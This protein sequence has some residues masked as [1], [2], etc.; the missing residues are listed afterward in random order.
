MNHLHGICGD[1]RES[2]EAV[3]LAARLNVS[4]S[5][6]RS[7]S[8][9]ISLFVALSVVLC[10][11]AAAFERTH[12]CY[13]KADGR[14]PVCAKG[15]ASIP[16]RWMD[17]CTTWRH[18]E[19]FPAEFLP[20]VSSSFD[21][22][23]VVNGAYFEV[24][25]AGST[26]QFGA[27]YDCKVSLDDNE[28]VVSYVTDW[29]S[30]LAGSDVVALTSV[31]YALDDGEIL[32]ADIRMNGEHFNWEEIKDVSY[33]LQRV[34][35][36]NI[37]THE[38][39]HFLGLDHTQERNYLGDGM[40]MDAT[41]WALTFS[42]EIKRRVLDRDDMAGLREIYPSDNAPDT[43]C[44]PPERIGHKELP[45]GFEPGRHICPTS[46]RGCDAAG[47]GSSVP[48]E[49]LGIAV[50]FLAILRLRARSYR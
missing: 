7:I 39:G 31:V 12:T 13:T 9:S 49:L 41:M 1:W 47:E 38:V 21:T 25:Y 22:W 48:R 30:S 46:K 14:T 37:M 10:S 8:L 45:E 42:N 24:Y 40:A 5:I 32:D 16:I 15:Q 20:A 43:P 35:V 18:H 26:A 44:A 23:N 2:L 28:N 50:G 34:D 19:D 27:A 11:N 33:D 17:G 4:F 36:Q 6:V 29:S 3:R